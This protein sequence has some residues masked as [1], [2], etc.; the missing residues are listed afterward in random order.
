MED[1]TSD[2]ET[3]KKAII[4]S[5]KVHQTRIILIDPLASLISHKSLDEQIAWM[6]FEEE[7]RRIYGVTFINVA[8]TR[9]ST[10]GEVAHSEGGNISFS[11]AVIG[12]NVNLSSGYGAEYFGKVTAASKLGYAIGD[13]PKAEPI[14]KVDEN[15]QVS[16][17]LTPTQRKLLTSSNV[18]FKDPTGKYPLPETLNEPDTNRLARRNT[19]TNVF[20]TKKKFR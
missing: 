2:L 4:Q 14:G 1:A 15:G 16:D 9:K 20:Q 8:H 19:D 7:T 12:R 13:E 6:N 17:G 18:G 11:Q 3:M 5:I 10:S